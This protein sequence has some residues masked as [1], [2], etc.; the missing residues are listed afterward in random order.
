MFELNAWIEL[1]DSYKLLRVIWL[2]R[3]EL[4]EINIPNVIIISFWLWNY[5]HG[6][7]YFEI[8]PFEKLNVDWYQIRET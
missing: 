6:G 2:D 7:F 3:Q 5:Y 4:F 1:N 8:S